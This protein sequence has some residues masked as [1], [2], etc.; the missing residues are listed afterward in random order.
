M[1]PNFGQGSATSQ[2]SFFNNNRSF[3]SNSAQYQP[4][5]GGFPK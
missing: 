4:D 3:N 5:T 2:P 1:F